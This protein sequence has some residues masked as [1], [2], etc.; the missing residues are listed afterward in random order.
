MRAAG[1]TSSSYPYSRSSTPLQPPASSPQPATPRPLAEPGSFQL[2]SPIA[3]GGLSRRPGCVL[4][5][6]AVSVRVRERLAVPVP[7][8]VERHRRLVAVL[9][10]P[11]DG[12][13]PLGPVR[14][15]EHEK[16][17]LSRCLASR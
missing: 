5:D 9:K 13:R 14:Q 2:R 3:P 10:Q 11:V 4:E 12:P 17:V 16:V 7:I 15:V 1:S 6:D 8:R